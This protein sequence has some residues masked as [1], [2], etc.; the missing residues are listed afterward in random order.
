MLDGWEVQY[1]LNPLSDDAAID[2]DGDGLSNLL[3]HNY[4]SDPTDAQSKPAGYYQFEYDDNG[5]LLNAL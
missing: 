1:G 4:G 2:S 5:N 3:E